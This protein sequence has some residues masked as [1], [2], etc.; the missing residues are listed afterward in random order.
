MSLVIGVDAHKQQH[1]LVA[2]DG[3]GRDLST[4]TI[5]NDTAGY[6]EAYH[7]AIQ[8]GAD[9]YW[10]VENSGHLGHRFAQYLVRQDECVLEVSPN[11]THRQRRHSKAAAKSDENDALAV[12]RIALQEREALPVVGIDD[13][14]MQVRLLVEQRDNLVGEQTRFINQLHRHLTEVDP[15][16]KQHVGGVNGL[17]VLRYCRRFPLKD[18]GPIDQ[19]RITLIRQL[20][21]LI[22]ELKNQ[23][24][25]LETRIAPLVEQIAPTLQ[26]IDGIGL[27][28]AAQLI[29]QVGPIERIASAAALAQYAGL[30]PIRHGSAGQYYHRVNSR[31]HRRLKWVFHLI[32]QTQTRRNPLARAYVDKKKAEGKTGKHAFRCLKRRMV[33]IVYA[34]WKK[35]QP[36][37]M[38][39]SPAAEA[40]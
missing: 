15:Q 30:A 28:N 39:Q 27:L 32:A 1:T 16:Y 9:R 3:T 25:A 33:D 36:Y 37:Q 40:A 21:T 14:S 20:A 6:E 19:V 17:K 12:A 11:L 5:A 10:G 23:I 24:S 13:D 8:L 29:A 7:W 22:L 31:G 26:S 2:I 35:G 34:V 38:P 4:L 18:A